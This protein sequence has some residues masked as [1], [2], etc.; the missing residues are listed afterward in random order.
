M[1]FFFVS[2]GI[3]EGGEKPKRNTKDKTQ[4]QTQVCVRSTLY[5]LSMRALL[6][7]C[8]SSFCVCVCL[9]FFLACRLLIILATRERCVSAD[10]A[11][12]SPPSAALIASTPACS[13]L[14]LAFLS[15]H[16]H[17]RRAVSSEP[18]VANCKGK[19]RW[20]VSGGIYPLV[21]IRWYTPGVIYP[22]VYIRGGI[23]PP[24]YTRWY[25]PGGTELQI[26]WCIA[27]MDVCV[28]LEGP[29]R[30]VWDFAS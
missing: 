21:Y 25:T 11:A 20:D 17:S 8:V 12:S 14:S 10:A 13:C 1:I 9:F 16:C 27:K 29:K 26:R 3:W 6:A 30:R 15:D 28:R 18:C 7:P 19:I 23:Y 22:A 2:C 4:V 24:V 5:C